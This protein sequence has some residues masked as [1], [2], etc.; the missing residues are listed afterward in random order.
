[1]ERAGPW[2]EEGERLWQSGE[3][4][5][6]AC[7]EA[8]VDWDTVLQFDESCLEAWLGKGAIRLHQGLVRRERE[9]KAGDEFTAAI[10]NPTRAPYVR[11]GECIVARPPRPGIPASR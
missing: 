10:R 2:A 7:Q 11:A 4:P 1:M 8:I 5:F 9:Q 6:E 3:E